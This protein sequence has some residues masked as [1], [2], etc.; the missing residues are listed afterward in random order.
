M[1]KKMLVK[2]DPYNLMVIAGLGALGYAFWVVRDFL[3]MLV[4]ALVI[5]TFIED[6]V[7]RGQK[8]K[9]PRVVSVIIF[10]TL[11]SL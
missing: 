3:L 4:V 6:F 2:F 5:S 8:Y 11:L 10:Y 9:L 7:Q 1:N